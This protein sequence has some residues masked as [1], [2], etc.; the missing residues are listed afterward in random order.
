MPHQC[1]SC[2]ETFADGSTDLL[3]GC[4][5]CDGTRFFYTEEPLDGDEREELKEKTDDDVE[6]MLQDIVEGDERPDMGDDIWSREAWEAWIRLKSSDEDEL[7]EKAKQMIEDSPDVAFERTEP[8]DEEDDEPSL[9]EAVAAA[10]NADEDADPPSEEPD[11]EVVSETASDLDPGPASVD[12]DAQTPESDADE[13]VQ[14]ELSEV[15]ETTPPGSVSSNE[16]TPPEPGDLDAL[17]E[18][19]DPEERPSTLNISG[20]GEY[21]IDVERLMED[22]P[23]IVERDGSFMIHL[24]SVFDNHDD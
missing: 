5:G 15:E 22:S 9:A 24:P 10:K 17:P 1:L 23:V 21:E 16:E 13:T 3:Q 7:S 20:P 14:V 19:V 11:L 12:E 2:G 8:A 6:E 4:P 18:D